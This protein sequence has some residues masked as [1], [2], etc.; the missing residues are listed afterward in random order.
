LREEKHAKKLFDDVLF[1]GLEV[2]FLEVAKGAWRLL[3]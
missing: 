2:A 1:E 3:V